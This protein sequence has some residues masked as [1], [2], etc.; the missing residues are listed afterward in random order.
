VKICAKIIFSVPVS[1]HKAAK[2]NVA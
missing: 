1:A 2:E